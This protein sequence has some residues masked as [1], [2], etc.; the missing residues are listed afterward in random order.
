[1][2]DQPP[3]RRS[4]PSGRCH[5]VGVRH[6]SPACA[7]L[8]E[9]TLRTV[10]P[11]TVLIE[12]P[13]DLNARL[14]ELLL[15]GH[16]PP[17]ALYSFVRHP[18][19][20]P[21]MPTAMPPAASDP[22]GGAGQSSAVGQASWYPL[23]DYSPEWVALQV[24]HE[25]G[26]EL[27]FMDL[28]AWHEAFYGLENV[29]ADRTDRYAEAIELLCRRNG[30]SGHD[31]LWDH[32]FEGV[33]D[34]ALLAEALEVY[35][36]EIR[37]LSAAA[38][39]T[40]P[41]ESAGHRD[42]AREAHMAAYVRAALERG[43][44]V[45]VVCGGFHAPVLA[46]LGPAG[47]GDTTWLDDPTWDR[48]GDAGPGGWPAIPQPEDGIAETY[49]IPYSYHRLDAF[50]GY[51]AG[52]P[53]PGYYEELHRRGARAA[54]DVM[55]QRVAA[56]LR[57]ANRR[58]S[59]ADLVAVRTQTDALARL[60]GHPVPLRADLADGL[61]SVL[62]DDA[63]DEPF[64][65]E[66]RGPLGGRT[67]PV[68]VEIV[69]AFSGERRG[70]LDPATPQP[71]LVLDAANELAAVG[72]ELA[73]EPSEL[74]ADLTV[75]RDR[76]RS[77]VLNRFVVLGIDG[78]ERGER[79]LAVRERWRL[80]AA[81]DRERHL[82]EASVYG[83][84]LAAAAE[85]AL[86]ER[87]G[88]TEPGAGGATATLV[89]G[90]VRDALACDLGRLVPRALDAAVRLVD[91]ETDAGRLGRV[92][93]DLALLATAERL[94]PDRATGPA[95][96]LPGQ[97]ATLGRRAVERF[98]W[99]LEAVRGAT[100]TEDE[101]VVAGI[102]AMCAAHRRLEMEPELALAVLDRRSVDPACPPA[103]R[104]ACLGAA[105]VLA[106][107]P[108]AASPGA[109]P[110]ARADP[111]TRAVVALRSLT[112][113]EQVGDLLSGLF[114]VARLRV[115]S[116]DRLLGAVDTLVGDWTDDEFLTMLPALRR[117]FAWFP[118][119]ER[120]RIAERIVVVR[121]LPRTS[122]LVGRIG[123]DP[124]GVGVGAALDTRIDGVMAR[125]GLE[126]GFFPAG[127]RSGS[128]P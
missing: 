43:G 33:D 53:S 100:S 24:G 54:A 102:V 82:I 72:V 51:Q 124:V 63:A 13:C 75:E 78:F 10:R 125:Y 76:Q 128:G 19:V 66:R 4:P 71:P 34:L 21:A 23:C 79:G 119:R 44:D 115:A 96:P 25:L 65:W 8:V 81:P 111:M 50:A 121:G 2:N 1:V 57:A 45:V 62:L 49:L 70:R 48:G 90:V 69:A 52:M 5:V 29:H 68:L 30:V 95:H 110:M 41:G 99:L 88:A 126:L 108:D 58:V 42:A 92:L 22:E 122:R 118:P 16:R 112:P 117:A 80:W 123:A 103:A 31:A 39:A 93:D 37:R 101:A 107:D 17:I 40:Q 9:A 28:P 94:Q 12:G 77:A 97:I 106:V 105:W 64:P 47:P 113:G 20:P 91:A 3:G 36:V 46:A 84:T 56:R 32:L 120:A 59:T 26:C 73:D 7:R 89:V 14:G 104:G 67:H 15:A 55:T 35:F 114:A 127:E 6:H 74:L 85:G 116:D 18:S 38:G 87:L 83:P 27:A 86:E 11:A 98:L 61:A 60:R 109:D